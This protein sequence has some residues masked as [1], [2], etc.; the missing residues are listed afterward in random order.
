[1]G[2]RLDKPCQQRVIAICKKAVVES[3]L[4]VVKAG[5]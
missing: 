5:G 3:D 4:E 1:M 2:R